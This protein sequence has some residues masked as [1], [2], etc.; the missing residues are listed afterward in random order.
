MQYLNLDRDLFFFFFKLF[1]RCLRLGRAVIRNVFAPY[2]TVWEQ[3][4]RSEWAGYWMLDWQRHL[5]KSVK[6]PLE[7]IVQIKQ[8]SFTN[9][10]TSPLHTLL[11]GLRVFVFPVFWSTLNTQPLL[12]AAVAPSWRKSPG[13]CLSEAWC[14]RVFLLCFT[15]MVSI[16]NCEFWQLFLPVR[17]NWYSGLWMCRG[18]D[19]LGAK[20]VACWAVASRLMFE[21]DTS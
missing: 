6:G 11:S 12:T 15:Q 5:C 18:H 9:M 17:E 16:A 7:T 3:L 1:E 14:Y 10:P 19:S 21:L 4:R 2:S 8:C 13:F 20:L